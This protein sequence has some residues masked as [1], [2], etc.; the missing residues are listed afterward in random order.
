MCCQHSDRK[1]MNSTQGSLSSMGWSVLLWRLFGNKQ[2]CSNAVNVSGNNL[3]I[4][5]TLHLI[6][7]NFILPGEGGKLHPAEASCTEIHKMSTFALYQAFYELTPIH[8][9]NYDL[10]S[11]RANPSSTTWQQLTSWNPSDNRFHR[12]SSGLYEGKGPYFLQY[13]YIP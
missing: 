4:T 7:C 10:I 9:C 2:I 13:F 12:Q 1:H 3:S 5:Q 8:I 6:I 11:N